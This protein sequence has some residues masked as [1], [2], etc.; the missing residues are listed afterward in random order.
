MLFLASFLMYLLKNSS[1]ISAL[2]IRLRSFSSFSEA[3]AQNSFFIFFWILAGIKKLP[4]ISVLISPASSFQNRFFENPLNYFSAYRILFRFLK[5]GSILPVKN[6]LSIFGFYLKPVFVK[7]NIKIS[8][9]CSYKRRKYI[10]VYFK[11]NCFPCFV[12]F[13]F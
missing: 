4:S 11:R 1:G 6:I 5:G 3:K 12:Y 7:T 8:L 2:P 13:S 9:N 10:S